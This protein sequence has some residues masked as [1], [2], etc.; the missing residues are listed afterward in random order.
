MFLSLGVVKDGVWRGK[1]GL[2]SELSHAVDPLFCGW[3]SMYSGLV[4]NFVPEVSL[5]LWWGITIVSN[6]VVHAGRQRCHGPII[7]GA[8]PPG[9]SAA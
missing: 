8:R 3:L 2:F 9:G 6:A 4:R 5:L 7:S 1:S